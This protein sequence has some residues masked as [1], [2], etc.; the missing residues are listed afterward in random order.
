MHH[1]YVSSVAAAESTY[2]TVLAT[3]TESRR[4]P[5]RIFSPLELTM[6]GLRLALGQ[7][8][9][10]RVRALSLYCYTFLLPIF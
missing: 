9:V 6:E 5:S 7:A 4:Y 8:D 10:I 2:E 3:A 1:H